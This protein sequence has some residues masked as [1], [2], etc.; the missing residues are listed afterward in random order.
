VLGDPEEQV[1]QELAT[2]G[3]VGDV[4][5]VQPERQALAVIRPSGAGACRLNAL[6]G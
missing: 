2:V 4:P 5:L 6:T 1:E 3:D